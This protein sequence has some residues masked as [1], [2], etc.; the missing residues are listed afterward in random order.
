MITDTSY[1]VLGFP[2][3]TNQHVDATSTSTTIIRNRNHHHHQRLASAAAGAQL[4][5]VGV[6][7]VVVVLDLRM[8][9]LLS[10]V[11]AVIRVCFLVCG[12][13][14]ML[15]FTTTAPGTRVRVRNST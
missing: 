13:I 3:S 2:A 8:A 5:V 1:Q 15:V 4:V 11:P 14:R 12:E 7:V 9:V 10:L 6:V